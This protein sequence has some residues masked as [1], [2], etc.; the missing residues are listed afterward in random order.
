MAQRRASSGGSLTNQAAR[1]GAVVDLL[2]VENRS[3]T[4]CV[5]SGRRRGAGLVQ[6]GTGGLSAERVQVGSQR[7]RSTSTAVCSA[8]VCGFCC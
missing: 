4:G 1:R 8:R 2:E 6:H 3:A 7:R 5:G